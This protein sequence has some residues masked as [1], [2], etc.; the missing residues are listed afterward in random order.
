M[1]ASQKSHLNH[2]RV[3]GVIAP[4]PRPTKLA[5]ALVA[6]AISI[7]FIIVVFVIDVLN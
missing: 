5:A 7:P 4:S 6:T 3:A 1:K 2:H